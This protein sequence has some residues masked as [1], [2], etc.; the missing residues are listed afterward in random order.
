MDIPNNFLKI[1]CPISYLQHLC[2]RCSQYSWLAQPAQK[3][4]QQTS[5]TTI[6]KGRCTVCPK[7]MTLWT[8][9]RNWR[10]SKW[11]QIIHNDSPLPAALEPA[12]GIFR[13]LCEMCANLSC[14]DWV[15][16]VPLVLHGTD[17][18]WCMLIKISVLSGHF[19]DPIKHYRAQL[20]TPG[21]VQKSSLVYTIQ[22]QNSIIYCKEICL[23]L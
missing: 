14:Q 18:M 11:W 10:Q 17:A 4:W 3:R 1:V 15:W 8:E 5:G 22:Y 13:G 6:G 12:N 16:L 23:I 20:R 21:A 7:W 19:S 9:Q 2:S